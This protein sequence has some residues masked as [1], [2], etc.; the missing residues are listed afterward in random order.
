MSLL[1]RYVLRENGKILG[2]IFGV[3]SLLC[4]LID[5]FERWDDLLEHEVPTSMGLYYMA[6]RIPQ[7]IVYIIPVSMLL[8][9]FITLG[10]MGR[11]NELIALKASGASGLLIVR[12]ML[13]TAAALCVISFFWAESLVPA[14]NREAAR[15]WQMEVKKTS[16]RSIVTGSEVWL[17]SPSSQG[18][19]F[20]RIGFLQLPQAS[21]PG[22][23]KDSQLI[24]NDVS[25]L[26]LDR[27]FRL[28][29]R[30]D[31]RQMSWEGQH[32]AFLDGIRWSSMAQDPQGPK[33]E[34]FENK[35][36]ALPEK[37]EDFQWVRQEVE[38][39]GFF[40][41]LGYVERARRE[42]FDATS[43]LTDLH[44]K[45][46]SAFFSLVTALF[47][48]PLA[49]RIPPRAGGLAL[50]VVL[51]MAIGFLYYLLLAL[52]LALGHGGALPPFIGAWGANLLFGSVG[53]WWMLH[54]RQ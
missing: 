21:L 54:M 33:V 28:M 44:F 7:Y 26:R 8:G 11:R 37:P 43:Q 52:G 42:G 20:Y 5:F 18:M 45:V 12:P 40:E 15:I 16:Q 38:S 39:M 31:A 29:E 30:V 48:I 22:P 41:L 14:A 25:V 6:C 17:R 27:D 2:W 24:L 32:W 51:S 49:M 36:I 9:G 1:F 46:A 53:L 50:G 34:R 10:L 19:T 35:T 47:T 3:L 13:V 23:G 4:F